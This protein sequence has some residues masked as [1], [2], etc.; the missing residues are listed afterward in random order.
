MLDLLNIEQETKEVFEDLI[1]AREIY[2]RMPI[3]RSSAT[4]PE[5]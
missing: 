1:E 2:R 3:L 4:S 5:R